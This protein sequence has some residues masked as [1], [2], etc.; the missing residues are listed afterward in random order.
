MVSYFH[1]IGLLMVMF[2]VITIMNIPTLIIYGSYNNYSD[3]SSVSM[4]NY[5][6]LGNMGFSSTRCGNAGMAAN[7]IQLS[8]NI[9]EISKIEAFGISANFED[10]SY[11]MVN[12]TSFCHSSINNT[13]LSKKLNECKNKTECKVTNLKS[14][15]TANSKVCGDEDA[16]FHVMYY[17][18]Q[19]NDELA[20]KRSH[21]SIISCIGIFQ[22]LFI[23]IMI[24]MAKGM[25]SITQIEW[26]VSTVTAG[27]YTCDM[28]I[29][30]EQ[31]TYFMDHHLNQF[32]NESPG[33]ALKLFLKNELEDKLT[34]QVESQGFENVSRI[35]IADINFSYANYELIQ[36]LKKKRQLYKK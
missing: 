20:T 2:T 26:D 36:G 29:T 35:E 1:M 28:L 30:R 34:N 4:V 23:L 12:K 17:C 22:S 24:Y 6:S 8:C 14:Y 25:T 5:V 10:Q 33:F 16:F 11:C 13:T 15:I 9:G 21:A 3:L 7:Q 31:Y 19:S 32:R 27:D 18:S